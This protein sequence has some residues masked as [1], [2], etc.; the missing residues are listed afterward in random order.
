MPRGPGLTRNSPIFATLVARYKGLACRY[1][2][3]FARSA[4]GLW[5]VP[6]PPLF[7]CGRCSLPAPEGRLG[8]KRLGTQ[9]FS[10]QEPESA[11]GGA[12]I[13]ANFVKKEHSHDL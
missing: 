11:G 10:R 1:A 13:A 6:G 5:P 4:G 7:F 2:A 9:G 12:I 3:T 8:V